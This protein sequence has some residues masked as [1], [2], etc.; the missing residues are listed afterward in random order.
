MFV[1]QF[2]NTGLILLL[3]HANLS[4]QNIPILSHIIKSEYYDYEPDW[5]QTVGNKIVNTMVINSILP[6]VTLL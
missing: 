3:V 1:A 6:Y 2:F 5:Y 4:E